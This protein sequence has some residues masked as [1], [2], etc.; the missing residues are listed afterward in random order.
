MARTTAPDDADNPAGVVF[1]VDADLSQPLKFHASRY[2]GATVGLEHARNFSKQTATG[3]TTAIF[4]WISQRWLGIIAVMW[5]GA[6][7][8]D[9]DRSRLSGTWRSSGYW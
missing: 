3:P 4:L 9:E 5:S 7:Q 2:S 1:P 8:C 6:P